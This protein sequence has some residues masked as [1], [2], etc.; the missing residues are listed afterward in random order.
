MKTSPPHDT[1]SPFFL[2]QQAGGFK[3]LVTVAIPTYNRGPLLRLAI[4]SA[5]AQTYSNLEILILDN[6]SSDET[7]TVVLEFND[8]RIKYFRHPVNLGLT[9]NWEAALGLASGSFFLVLSDDDRLAI[10][11]I[12][13]LLLCYAAADGHEIAFAY[14][15]CRIWED[16]TAI[17]R[18]SFTAPQ[19]EPSANYRL[20]Y[21][22]GERINY[23]SATLFRTE[24]IRTVGGYA[25]Q[26]KATIDIGV[27]FA[28]SG[29]RRF[30]AYTDRDIAYYLFHQAN[31]TSSIT[32]N[33]HMDSIR[34][35]AEMTEALSIDLPDCD[36]Q[37]LRCICNYAIASTYT[38]LL[39]QSHFDEIISLRYLCVEMWKQRIIYFP[40]GSRIILIKMA[41]KLII[42][43]MFGIRRFSLNSL[44]FWNM[45]TSGKGT[46]HP[47]SN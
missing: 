44:K 6:A 21:L 41:T 30:V 15:P 36:D 11:A 31:T 42:Y 1:G 17:S 23:P 32:I 29:L 3:P 4:E 43:H 12:N 18:R 34:V 22:R 25:A 33:A 37:Q 38:Y 40:K 47:R 46:R 14:G 2:A 24:D 5:L 27:A 9:A 28:V 16:K 20:G 26:G 19:R 7:S 8:S 10:Q 39:L 45:G 35:L 13:D